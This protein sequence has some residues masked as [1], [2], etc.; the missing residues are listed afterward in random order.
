[1]PYDYY[2]IHVSVDGVPIPDNSMCRYRSLCIFTVSLCATHTFIYLC[3]GFVVVI[4]FFITFTLTLFRLFGIAHLLLN[5]W[6]QSVVLQ[7]TCV[8]HSV[9]LLSSLW[10]FVKP[11]LMTWQAH[12]WPC[13]DVSLPMYME[14]TQ[15]W[16][17]MESTPDFWGRKC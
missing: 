8:L 16:A 12:W 14:A 4:G 1:M 7:V 13:M 6:V 17:Q 11:T 5:L 3:F 9:I 2:E 15:T 10:T